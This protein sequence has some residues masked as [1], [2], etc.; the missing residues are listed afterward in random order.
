[1]TDFTREWAESYVEY[2]TQS[3]SDCLHGN[4]LEW[5]TPL[6]GAEMNGLCGFLRVPGSDACVRLFELRTLVAKYGN[7]ASNGIA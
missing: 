3:I 7:A 2:G 4:R 5:V 1:M 6:S